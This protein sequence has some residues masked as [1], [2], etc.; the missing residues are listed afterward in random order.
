MKHKLLALGFLS[1]L[2]LLTSD[3]P[4]YSG[5]WHCHR[6]TTHITCRPYNAFTPI[7]WGNLICD[8][9]CPSPCGMVSGCAGLPPW[10]NTMGCGVAMMPPNGGS[11][12]ATDLPVPYPPAPGGFN[13]PAPRPMPM[14][15]GPSAMMMYP[16]SGVSQANYY[17]MYTP[18]MP[19]YYVPTYYNPYQGYQP[20]PYYWYNG[21]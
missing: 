4:A 1:L 3:V 11:S 7:C 18:Y 9:C 19:N 21:Y 10:T 2:G 14:P 15:S 20:M 17:P 13:P 6:C 16:P 12:R 8:G 5:W